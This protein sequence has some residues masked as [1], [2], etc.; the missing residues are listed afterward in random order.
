MTRSSRYEP[1][2][3]AE[4]VVY[5][6]VRDHYETFRAQ[7]EHASDGAGLPRFVQ[8][9]FEGFLRCG[10][11]AGGFARFRCAGCRLD[12][13]V[14]FSCKGRAVCASCGGR[15]MAERA[16]HL[17]DHVFPEVPVRQW[18]LTLPHRIRYLL[19]W[20]HALCRAVVGVFMRTVLGF[21]R[22]RA[23]VAKGVADGR[24]G[25]VAIVQRFGAALNTNIHAHAMVLDGVFAHDET[26]GLRFHQ[27]T[28]P[29]DAEMDQVLATIARRVRRVLVRRGVWDDAG[30]DPWA[31]AD[32]VLAGL[33]GASVQG[34]R[35]LGPQAGA[36]VRR[37]GV[38]ADLAALGVPRR[39]AC[40][41][42]AGGFDLHA[43][44]AVP[45]GDRARLERLC[46]YALRPPIAADRVRLTDAG[47]VLLE[48]RHRWN[49]GTTHLLFE[50]LELLERL[51]ALTPRPRINLVLYYGVLGARSAWRARLG[52]P[53]DAT[54]APAE[55]GAGE[56]CGTPSPP[57]RRTNLL[58]A[59]LMARSFGVDVLAC[60]QCGDRLHLIAIIER[61]AV[62]ERI[63]A[64][65][66]VPTAPPVPRPPRA[67]PL[68]FGADCDPPVDD[69]AA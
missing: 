61:R 62:I 33:T 44:V 35:A 24:S 54:P 59:Q 5:Q 17:V 31:E 14:P 68:P 66:G 48:L 38:S 46:R 22:R 2:S 20:D 29:T 26:S 45:A 15:R 55:S 23:R 6:V 1:R 18:V 58:W 10:F 49:D 7:A 25:A 32:P 47:Y 69:E 41:A 63:L 13:L 53:A 27:G 39:G 28:P 57:R 30:D 3:P 52:S 19:A 56:P 8:E 4:G 21:L 9:E 36:A 60:P 64:H 50:P 43:G 40:H 51:A 42:H 16:A 67:P 11:L 37:C 12:R 34:R 65:L